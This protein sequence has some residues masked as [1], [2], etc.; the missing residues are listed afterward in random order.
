MLTPETVKEGNPRSSI[1]VNLILMHCK[2]ASA[3]RDILF[4]AFKGYY[5]PYLQ[6]S[7]IFT[8]LKWKLAQ[9][10]LYLHVS[11]L[12]HDCIFLLNP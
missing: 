2:L 11:L 9:C 7:Q 3:I 5:I 6:Y 10:L 8:I 4:S 12:I 1:I